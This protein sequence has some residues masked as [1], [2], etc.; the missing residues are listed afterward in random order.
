MYDQI[1]IYSLAK[2]IIPG[3]QSGFRKNHSTTSALLKIIDDII[4]NRDKDRVTLLVLL[5][6]SN[7]FNAMTHQLLCAEPKY[8]G[9]NDSA[10]SLIKSYLTDRHQRVISKCKMSN[11]KNITHGAPQGSILAPLLFIIYTSDF[12]QV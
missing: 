11:A 4:S 3:N 10:Y 5:H 12:K 2:S 6:Y 1:Y 8:F 7:A 9:F